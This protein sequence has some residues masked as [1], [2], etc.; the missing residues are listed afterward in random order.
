MD[1]VQPPDPLELSLTCS[2]RDLPEQ[3]AYGL[4]GG[5]LNMEGGTLARRISLLH[6]PTRP[7]RFGHR[8]KSLWRLISQ[9]SLNPVLLTG[10]VEPI[11]GLLKLH[12]PEESAVSVRQIEGVKDLVQKVVLLSSRNGAEL[13]RY[14]RRAGRAFLV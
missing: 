2:N 3:L 10:G 5:D 8:D 13:S 7:V 4:P 12:A 6:R 14:L 11:R 9:L 1:A